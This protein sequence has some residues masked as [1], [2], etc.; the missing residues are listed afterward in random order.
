[1]GGWRAQ[2]KRRW[3]N[4]KRYTLNQQSDLQT[5]VKNGLQEFLHDSEKSQRGHDN[6]NMQ[7]NQRPDEDLL[8]CYNG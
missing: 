4:L 6:I 2:G 5:K 8:H 1:L 3:P 7:I